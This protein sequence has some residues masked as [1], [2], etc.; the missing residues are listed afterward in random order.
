M[1]HTFLST[2]SRNQIRILQ[3]IRQRVRITRSDLVE[4]SGFKLLTVTKTVARFL[5]DGLIVEAG[6][7]DSTGGRKATLLSINPHFRYTLAVDMGASGARIGVVGMD[8]SVIEDRFIKKEYRMPARHL[9][10]EE[11][12]EIL[13]ELTEK[14]GQEKILGLGI[15]ISGS[16]RHSV[17]RIVFCP[18][19]YGW[20]EVDVQKEFG[21]PLGIPVLVDTVARCMALAE[22]TLGAGQGVDNQVTVSIGTSV[23]SGIIMDG[24]IYRG[25][26]EAAGE[27]GH[28]T[29]R[30]NGGRCTCGN[31]GCLENYV[32]QHCITRTVSKKL[33]EFQG[34]SPLRALV[35]EGELPAPE[36]ICQAAEQ[37]DPLVLEVLA[38]CADT[39]GTAISYLANIVNPQVIILGGRAIEH[40]PMLVDEVKRVV[41][42]RSAMVTQRNLSI[43]ASLLREQSTLIGSALQVIDT[44]FDEP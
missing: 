44:L 34:Y 35:P 19:L 3:H 5:E 4:V 29:V 39:V 17:G 43:R 23:S 32:N 16:V 37:G 12:R 24:R 22:L 41:K 36:Q 8:G 26:D 10:V 38:D 42:R 18:N 2:Y 21:D 11:L 6:H 28:T 25:A 27:I 20:N 13:T 14:Y 1:L 15:G 7:E 9:S 30:E 33:R 40:Y 31:I